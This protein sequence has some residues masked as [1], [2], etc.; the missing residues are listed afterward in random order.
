MSVFAIWEGDD[1][2]ALGADLIATAQGWRTHE[3][4]WQLSSDVKAPKVGDLAPDFALQD[5]SGEVAVR[6]S[7]FRGK[8]PVALA[9]GI[10]T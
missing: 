1:G 9:F 3:L 2:L 7:D 8:R 4:E 5:P 6:L 10:Y